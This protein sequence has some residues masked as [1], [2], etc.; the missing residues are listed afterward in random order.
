M[1]ANETLAEDHNWMSIHLQRISEHEH[2]ILEN[3]DDIWGEQVGISFSSLHRSLELE[4]KDIPGWLI[5][6][7]SMLFEF[8][9][10][11]I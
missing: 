1:E 2:I 5:K 3:I 6:I 9:K 4:Q 11:T 7:L 10:Q 8:I